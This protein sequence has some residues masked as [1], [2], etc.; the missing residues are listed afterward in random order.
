MTSAGL[1][2]DQAP[3]N[4]DRET[5]CVAD[6]RTTPNAIGDLVTTWQVYGEDDPRF[7]R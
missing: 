4:P 6:A 3:S 1:P 7:T 5:W 2:G